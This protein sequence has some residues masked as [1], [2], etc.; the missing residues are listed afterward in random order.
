LKLAVEGPDSSNPQYSIVLPGRNRSVLAPT[1][2]YS[3]LP[4]GCDWKLD[5]TYDA[6]ISGWNYIRHS[7]LCPPSYSTQQ[8][9]LRVVL[10]VLTFP[11]STDFF[12]TKGL[13]RNALR[14]Q[15]IPNSPV[16]KPRILKPDTQE[17]R[18]IISGTHGF[19]FCF[20]G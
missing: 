1:T 3:P 19:H 14:E 12:P 10:R 16:L 2:G 17:L 5:T 6:R 4:S 18:S 20:R 15:T 8:N 9:L 7:F 13:G 11:V